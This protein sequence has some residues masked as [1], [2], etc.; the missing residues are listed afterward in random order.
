MRNTRFFT[1]LTI[2]CLLSFSLSA[3]SVTL[4]VPR[5]AIKVTAPLP[6][7]FHLPSV[8]PMTLDDSDGDLPVQEVE[9]IQ[10]SFS[11]AGVQH[12]SVEIDNVCGSIEVVGT[13]SDEAQLTVKKSV[14]AVTKQKH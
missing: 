9:T 5:P 13:N 8:F 1:V 3:Q 2:G 6:L 7:E 12:K 11:I 10:K 14:R 4:K